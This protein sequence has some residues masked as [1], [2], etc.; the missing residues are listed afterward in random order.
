MTDDSP[1][2]EEAAPEWIELE[3][4]RL[5]VALDVTLATG[6]G[7][8][9]GLYARRLAH[10]LRQTLAVDLYPL[11][12]QGWSRKPEP[13]F[14]AR[15]R[16]AARLVG[17]TNLWLPAQARA[18]EPQILHATA[19]LGP[20]SGP[21]ALVVTVPDTTF[22]LYPDEAGLFW[23][24]YVEPLLSRVLARAAAII[25]PSSRVAADVP[26]LYGAGLADRI[27]VI[28]FGVEPD[29]PLTGVKIPRTGDLPAGFQIAPGEPMPGDAAVLARLGLRRPYIVQ[30][31]DWTTRHRVPLA[32][33]AFGCHVA[34]AHD[35]QLSLALVGGQTGG[36]ARAVAQERQESGVEG[37][38][39]ALGELAHEQM[40]VVY[41]NAA[42]V[43][44][45]T[46]YEG[47]GL[48]ALEAM[49]CG[50]PVIAAPEA[51]PAPHAVAGV[52][53]EDPAAWAAALGRVLT[54][55]DLR[56]HLTHEALHVAEEHSWA[57]TAADTLEL[58]QALVPEEP[59]GG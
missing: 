34:Q 42:A 19:W 15:V 48:A 39:V 54:S 50:V 21:G 27:N 33:A 30:V 6:V 59:S 51:V 56:E 41:R 35:E 3:R 5:R 7:G 52:E 17:A 28:P 1:T 18:L 9:A 47:F 8:A 45:T 29:Y 16:R 4:P 58:Y 36:A 57:R 25:V 14:I 22:A 38:I 24:W 20:L 23:R 46:Q 40:P 12:P 55:P 32:I 44:L 10:H 31:G 53:G 43:L 13:G 49:A 2:I 37:R 11:V 26:R